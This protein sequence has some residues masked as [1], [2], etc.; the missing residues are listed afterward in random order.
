MLPF[1]T[2]SHLDEDQQELH[3]QLEVVESSIP[4]VGLVE[5]SEDRLMDRITLYQVSVPAASWCGKLPH[6]LWKLPWF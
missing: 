6:F 2:W 3:R 1:Q 5:E 4:S